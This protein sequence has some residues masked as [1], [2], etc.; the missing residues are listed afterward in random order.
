MNTKPQPTVHF[1]KAQWIPV[2]DNTGILG[3]LSEK[4][5]LHCKP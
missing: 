3:R 5:K 1:D 4:I 2:W